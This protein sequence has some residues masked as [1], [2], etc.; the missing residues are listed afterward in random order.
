[1]NRLGAIGAHIARAAP[2]AAAG[3]RAAISLLE[4]V[5]INS[6]EY[7]EP[8]Q[9]FFDMLGMIPASYC[10][11]KIIHANMGLSQIHM[12]I[13][14]ENPQTWNGSIGLGY[15]RAEFDAAWELLQA[16]S[17]WPAT[18]VSDEEIATV[19]PHSNNYILHVVSDEWVAASRSRGS[20]HRGQEDEKGNPYRRDAPATCDG[21]AA[22]CAGILYVKVAV[23]TGKAARIANFYRAA[24][25]AE[26]V[27]ETIGEGGLQSCTVPIGTATHGQS[28]IYMDTAEDIPPYDGHHLA[29]Y[30]DDYAGGYQASADNNLIWNNPRFNDMPKDAEE[31]MELA[32]FRMKDIVDMDSGEVLL[33][34]EHEIRCRYANKLSPLLP[35]AA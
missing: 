18:K 27:I 31:A 22:R 35:D 7:D 10:S 29:I 30:L 1:M 17:E 20:V 21:D 24:F 2:A 13:D 12:P 4:H 19:G 6:A 15:S 14:A 25:G 3:G 5:N 33:E 11:P 9:Y 34:L 16:Q 32:Q 8:A 28:I 26:P 23:P